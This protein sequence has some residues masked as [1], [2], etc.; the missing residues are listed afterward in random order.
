V[1]PFYNEAFKSQNSGYDTTFSFIIG[2]DYDFEAEKFDIESDTFLVGY[3]L[4]EIDPP[5]YQRVIGFK[6][7]NGDYSLTIPPNGY[8]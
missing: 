6:E 3:S 7:R 2:F 4:N 5:V 1:I 8:F